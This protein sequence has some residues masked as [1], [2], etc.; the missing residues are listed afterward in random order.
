MEK[1]R[2]SPLDLLG[3]MFPGPNLRFGF[4][5]LRVRFQGSVDTPQIPSRSC[6]SSS[7][8]HRASN[9][10]ATF[11]RSA[12]PEEAISTVLC[13][14]KVPSAA[15]HP[16]RRGVG[17]KQHRFN[18]LS[19]RLRPFRHCLPPSQTEIAQVDSS[20]QEKPPIDDLRECARPGRVG[21]GARRGRILGPNDIRSNRRAEQNSAPNLCA[22]CRAEQPSAPN[23][24]AAGASSECPSADG[25][26]LP[27]AGRLPPLKAY[28]HPVA[29]SRRAAF[30]LHF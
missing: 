10:T 19:L 4:S 18:P 30:R 1:F 9:S 17:S 12:P 26:S 25:C 16:A 2:P 7:R 8:A 29:R 15:L 6:Y 23:L 22:A 3:K 28:Y 14:Q 13:G 21:L 27:A 24:R 5:T 20:F 11:C